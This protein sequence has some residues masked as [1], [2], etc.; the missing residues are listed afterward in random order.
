VGGGDEDDGGGVL[1]LGPELVPELLE[2]CPP[3]VGGVELPE[4]VGHGFGLWGS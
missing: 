3:P 1:E 2:W 4:W